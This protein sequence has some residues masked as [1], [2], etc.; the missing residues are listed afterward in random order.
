MKFISNMKIRTKLMLSFLSMLIIIALVGVMGIIS[1]KTI[2]RNTDTIYSYNLK[3]IDNLHII[4]ENIL[5]GR[6]ELQGMVFSRDKVEIENNIESLNDIK[7]DNVQLINNYE[8]YPLSNEAKALWTDFKDKLSEYR[9]AQDNTIILMK[10]L[11][12]K[13]TEAYFPTVQK[14]REEMLNLLNK[15]IVL[16][17]KMAQNNNE[18]NNA[19]YNKIINTMIGVMVLGVAVS[20]LLSILISRYIDNSI[21]EGLKFAKAIGEGDLTY[22][23][24]LNSQDELG[25]LG[26]E[27]DVAEKKVKNLVDNIIKQSNEG[28]TQS[29]VLLNSIENI[30]KKIKNIDIYTQ[31]IVDEISDNNAITEEITASIEE[32]NAAVNELSQ[33]SMDGNNESIKI[34]EKAVE[35]KKSGEV[36]KINTNKLC[37]EKEKNILEAIEDGKVVKE[38]K[39]MADAI[40]NI[41][42]QTNLL[43]LNAAIEAARAGEA[44]KGFA[45]VADEIRKLAEQSNSNVSNI[46]KV[47]E[48]VEHAFENLSDNS[49]EVI[50][51]INTNVKKDY[52]LFLEIGVNYEKDAKFLSDMSQNIASMSEEINATIDEISKVILN[53][54]KSLNSSNESSTEILTS[55]N[56]TTN[57]MGKIVQVAEKQSE[58]SSKLDDLV[59]KFKI[60]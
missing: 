21:K 60:E 12:F 50:D 23:I 18:A 16:N 48:E 30:T 14:T 15:L 38:V 37:K 17:D 45:V 8:K 56:E 39:I 29:E 5:N 26:R 46:Q 1:I 44:G 42:D 53:I 19:V 13:E 7:K 28:N 52:D 11:K 51:F 24:N 25:E 55:I 35:I 58:I 36:S 47:I 27:L 54:S 4:K 49:K 59:K 40:A 57:N 34:K 6:S 41:A 2:D 9:K 32:V 10:N 22:E 33:K 20:V 3:S 31:K 43:A